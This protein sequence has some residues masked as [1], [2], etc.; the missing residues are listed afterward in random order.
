MLPIP[1]RSAIAATIAVLSLT[2][3]GCGHKSGGEGSGSADKGGCPAGFDFVIPGP[4]ICVKAPKTDKPPSLENASNPANGQVR[5][6]YGSGNTYAFVTITYN[7]PRT[8][9]AAITGELANNTSYCDAPPKMEDIDGGSG[10]GKYFMCK[11]KKLEGRN[12]A[13]SAISTPKHFIS[14][15]GQTHGNPAVDEICKHIKEP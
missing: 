11:S 3:A 15:S 5:L 13:A 9:D 12:L 7:P 1:T 6:D 10:K 8:G 4:K 2:A 14:C